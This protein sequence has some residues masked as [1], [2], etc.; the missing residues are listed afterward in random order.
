[1]APR[2]SRSVRAAKARKRKG[3]KGVESQNILILGSLSNVSSVNDAII[4]GE[5]EVLGVSNTLSLR[6]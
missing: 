6:K 4:A 1:M 3:F 5:E 2:K